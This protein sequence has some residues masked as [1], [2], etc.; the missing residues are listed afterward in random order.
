MKLRKFKRGDNFFFQLLNDENKV[1]LE[2][3]SY[4]SKTDRD[5]GVESVKANIKNADRYESITEVGEHYFILKAGN[6]KEIAR[7]G[8][9]GSQNDL[10]NAL[11]YLQGGT[12]TEIEYGT[13]GITDDYRPISFYEER[14]GDVKDGFAKF[15]AEGEYYFCYNIDRVVYMISEGYKSEA[16]R[17]NGIASVEKNMIL[18]ER[19][20]YRQHLNGSYYFNLKAG[21]NQEIATSRWLESDGLRTWV[22]GKLNGKGGGI[23]P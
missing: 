14:S 16:S 5:N 23:A 18:D 13:D 3:Q 4:T 8:F 2:S 19:Y 7:S 15:E 9:Y 1:T 12:S 10:E 11:S 6:N 17:N 20:E 22:V 21:N